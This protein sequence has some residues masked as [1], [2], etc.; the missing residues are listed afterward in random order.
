M[1]AIRPIAVGD[2]PAGG[3]EAAE[4]DRRLGEMVPLGRIARPADVAWA[5]VFLAADDAAFITAQVINVDGGMLEQSRPPQLELEP[6][7]RPEDLPL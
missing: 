6:L 5:A 3:T 1:N 7:I 2:P 4:R